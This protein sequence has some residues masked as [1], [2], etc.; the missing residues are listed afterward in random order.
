MIALSTLRSGTDGLKSPRAN[1]DVLHISSVHPYDDVRIIYRECAVLRHAGFDVEAAFFD[2]PECGEVAGVPLVSLGRRPGSRLWRAVKA[3]RAAKAL[4]REI[5]PRIV[6]LHDPE[7]LPLARSLQQR[8][9]TV[10]YDAHEDLPRQIF[11]KPWIPAWARG[12]MSRQA[13]WLLPKLL[14]GTD[15]VIVAARHIDAGWM[16]GRPRV[17]LRNMPL[18][19]RLQYPTGGGFADREAAVVYAGLLSPARALH[20]GV[21][22]ALRGGA[23]VFLAGRGDKSYIDSLVALDPS[24]VNYVG[25]L[26][27]ERLD[28]LL[29]RCRL[30]LALLPP[31]PAYLEAVPSKVFDYLKAGLP[32][33]WS[34]FPYWRESLNGQLSDYAADPAA[35]EAVS[36]LIHRLVHDEA[37]WSQA[38]N[39]VTRCARSYP[40]AEE[41]SAQLIELYQNTLEVV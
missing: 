32:F 27:P 22:S 8:G 41:E 29:A 40:S 9:V 20:Y 38:R 19:S 30:G 33:V 13:Q 1:C 5:R 2:T 7:L 28:A 14:E 21:R 17:L 12:W 36:T 3:T 37:A 31:S 34:D 39:E 24:R 25:N 4:V 11:H 16:T 15:A 10:F 18:A 6:H 26:E 35:S 23:Q